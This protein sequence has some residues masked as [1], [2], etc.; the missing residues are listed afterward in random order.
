V[1]AK[2]NLTPE[3]LKV[4]LLLT[5][6]IWG[7]TAWYVA[8][9]DGYLEVLEKHWEWAEEVLTPGELKNEF[10]DKPPGMWQ[11]MMAT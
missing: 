7:Q 10:G 6:D 8:A 5:K 9:Y 4:K 1:W 2:K 11:Q 3:E